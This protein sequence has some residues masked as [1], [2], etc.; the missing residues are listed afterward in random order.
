MQVRDLVGARHGG[1]RRKH[2]ATAAVQKVD[3][4]V[5]SN[6]Q[7]VKRHDPENPL[8]DKNGDVWD[9]GVD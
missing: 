8:A 3:Q 1:A 9:A 6:T 4:I 2:H 7:A 5:Q